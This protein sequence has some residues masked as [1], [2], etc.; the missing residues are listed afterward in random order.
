MR[1]S[2]A[3][4]VRLSS[5]RTDLAVTFQEYT[6]S[7]GGRIECANRAGIVRPSPPRPT[8]GRQVELGRAGRAERWC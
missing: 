4:P 3:S 1:C 6:G 7:A 5:T 2:A 8:E